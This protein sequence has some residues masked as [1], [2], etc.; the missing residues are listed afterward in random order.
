MELL[1]LSLSL[2]DKLP[3]KFIVSAYSSAGEGETESKL[4]FFEDHIDWLNTIIKTLDAIYFCPTYFKQDG[5]QD[6]MIRAG[7]LKKDRSAFEEDLL[8]KIGQ[9]LY[10]ALFPRDSEVAKVLERAI[11]LAESSHIQLHIQFQFYADPVRRSQLPY[12]PW[13]LVHNGQK[14]LAQDRV[15][16]S[17]YIAHRSTPPNRLS[18]NKVNVLLVSSAAFDLEND[19]EQL[20]EIEQQAI[21][22]G[23]EKAKQK[24]HVFLTKLK[25]ATFNELRAYLT[26]NCGDKTPH[27]LHFDGHGIYGKRCRNG[28]CRTIHKGVKVDKCR[29]CGDS[30]TRPEGY[31]V[32]EDDNGKADYVSAQKLGDLLQQASFGNDT[33]QQR[34]VILAVLSACK[35]GMALAGDSAFNGI[36]QNLISRQVPAVVAMQY[37]VSVPAATAF[38]EQ[39]YRSLGQQNPVATAVSQGREA[40]GFDGNQWYRPVL[41]LR[42]KAN[43]GGQLFNVSPAS[44][45]RSSDQV[46]QEVSNQLARASFAKPLLDIPKENARKRA[47]YRKQAESWLVDQNVR[48]DLASAIAKKALDVKDLGIYPNRLAQQEAQKIFELNLYN[49]LNWLLR[50]FQVGTGENI[51]RFIQE[52]LIQHPLEVYVIALNCFKDEAEKRLEDNREVINTIHRYTNNLIQKIDSY[53]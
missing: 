23:I 8:V 49:C 9:K 51:D 53:L 6:W 3:F 24:K 35:S 48:L 12:Y 32:F 18:V 43:E 45:S 17:R 41:Y 1:R 26:E 25:V 47:D 39:F 37:L 31:L 30:L 36:A 2:I 14:F 13:E 5:E 33:E 10:Q 11:T 7:L 4:P 40:M 38:A 28:K 19:L 22:K 27:V 46:F 44:V 20:S 34:G 50:A 15:T 16:F 29:R 21:R 52:H 42:W